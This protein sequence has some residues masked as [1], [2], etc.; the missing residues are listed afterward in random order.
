MKIICV[1]VPHGQ[2]RYPTSGD[3]QVER[4]EFGNEVW[5]FAVSRTE[6]WRAA[7]AL[8]LHEYVEAMLTKNAGISVEQI[9]AWDSKQRLRRDLE[10]GDEAGC[11]Y[12]EQHRFAENLERLFVAQLGLTWDEYEEEIE[13]A[14]KAT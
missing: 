12:R 6:D 8:F 7:A 14:T 5:R 11:P 13:R 9:D 3:Y 10:P 2:Q 4:D 1:D